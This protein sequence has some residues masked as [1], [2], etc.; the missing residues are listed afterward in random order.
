MKTILLTLCSLATLAAP[1]VAQSQKGWTLEQCIEQARQN[2]I[3]V[4]QRAIAAQDAEVQL[5]TA[6]N[7][8]LPDLNATLGSNIY[9]GRGPSRDGTYKDNTQ[10]S[11][12]LGVSTSIPIFQGMLINKQIKGSKLNLEAAMQDM[13]R[14]KEDVAVNVM[15]LYLQVLFNK[16]L[17]TVAEQKLAL[18]TQQVQLN[19]ALV[20][21]GRQPISARYESEALQ[22]ND[23]LALVQARNELTLA[24]LNLS[25]ALNRPSAEG[26]DVQMPL[27]DSLSIAALHQLGD[28][29]RVY[30]YADAHRPM[31]A[32]ERTRLASSENALKI[33][34]AALYPT[35]A[36]SAGY[37]TNV[38]HSYATGALNANFWSQFRNNGNEYIGVSV[39]I[40]IFNRRATHNQIK[41]AHLAIRSQQ[42]TLTE[43]Q[44][45]LRKEIEQA[46]YAADGA[47]AKYRAADKALASARV[48]FDFEQ[49]K[50]TAGRSTIFNFNDARTR[51]EKAESELIQAK[52]E[53]L[54]RSKIL[55][56]Y[57]GK[58]LQL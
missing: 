49:E 29:D 22:T 57:N 28:P 8:R 46:Y 37:G 12:T 34:R 1:C 16:E 11:G 54:F 6:R 10:L 7:S 35:I 43:A 38:Y 44:Q 9:F 26:F 48:A 15:T 14:A 42:L 4:Q 51:M 40:P 36:L 25:Q 32:A 17:V 56:F 19:A 3:A 33:A 53:F 47:F 13:E 18:S 41:S 58:P 45:N 31:I 55:D 27:L 52:Y 30:D 24:L 20:D 21:E 39:N 5:S 23:E 2:N 50:M